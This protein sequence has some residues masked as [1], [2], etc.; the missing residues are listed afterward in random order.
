M[1]SAAHKSIQSRQ[2]RPHP[3]QRKAAITLR[4]LTNPHAWVLLVP[5]S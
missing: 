4:A 3:S 2:M 1:E 5:S